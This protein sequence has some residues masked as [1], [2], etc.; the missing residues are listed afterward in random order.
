[1]THC[2]HDDAGDGTG[3]F[4]LPGPLMAQCSQLLSRP[5]I[6]EVSV[7]LSKVLR[8]LGC[9]EPESPGNLLDF[10]PELPAGLLP[11]A[12]P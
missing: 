5:L 6:A 3:W 12:S 11:A 1:M 4:K 10:E 9:R 2:L 8:Q 7:G